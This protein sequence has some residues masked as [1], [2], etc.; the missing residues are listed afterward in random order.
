MTTPE[1]H[2]HDKDVH[3]F[4]LSG[5]G[6]APFKLCHPG[7]EDAKTSTAFFCEHCGTAIKNR[8]FVKSADGKVSVVG[9]DCLKKTGDAGLTDGVKRLRRQLRHEA[10]EEQRSQADETR[11]ANDRLHLNGKTREERRIGP[12]S[13]S[14][15]CTSICV[16]RDSSVRCWNAL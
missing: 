4:S 8:Y 9:V 13:N 14:I 11:K 1:N 10:R 5:L 3:T 12:G 7:D 15:P 16:S 2:T 6:D